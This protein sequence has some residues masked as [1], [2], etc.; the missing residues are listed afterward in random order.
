MNQFSIKPKNVAETGIADP[1]GAF[2]DDLEHRLSIGDRTGNDAQHFR[3]CRLLFQCLRKIARSRLHFV[4]KT[5]IFDCY[6]GL[7][8]ESC[9]DFDLLLGE[10]PDGL[11][12][13]HD[14][15]NRYSFAQ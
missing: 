8:G 11:A 14:H 15:A 5:R 9:Q 6:D 7:I 13:E 2:C 12:S 1:G 3:C 10:G 4:K